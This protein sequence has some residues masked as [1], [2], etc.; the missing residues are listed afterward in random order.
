MIDS[1]SE[2]HYHKCKYRSEFFINNLKDRVISNQTIDFRGTKFVAERSAYYQFRLP[3]SYINITLICLERQLN[4]YSCGNLK[5]IF[6][7]KTDHKSTYYE[8]ELLENE[9][10]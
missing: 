9:N 3:T 1:K 6:K 8:Y 7:K 5:V 4:M 10:L 2:N